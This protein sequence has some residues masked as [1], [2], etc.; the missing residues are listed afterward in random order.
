MQIYTS[1]LLYFYSKVIVHDT[2]RPIATGCPRKEMT[3]PVECT[4]EATHMKL[5]YDCMNYITF[6]LPLAW[7]VA[8]ARVCAWGEAM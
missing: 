5:Q 6:F 7:S 1:H 8:S 2:P 3:T 4:F